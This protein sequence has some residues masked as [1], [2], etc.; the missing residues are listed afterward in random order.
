MKISIKLPLRPAWECPRRYKKRV[1][2]AFDSVYLQTLLIFILFMKANYGK[3]LSFICQSLYFSLFYTFM[4]ITD[5]Q[6]VHCFHHNLLKGPYFPCWHCLLVSFLDKVKKKN[7]EK[8]KSKP[9]QAQLNN[10]ELDL[11]LVSWISFF[12]M[13]WC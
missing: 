11:N 10:M 12:P 6:Q 13:R 1:W 5:N 2:V 4:L 9:M 7:S 8:A 3:R